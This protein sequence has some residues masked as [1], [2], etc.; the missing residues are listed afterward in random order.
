MG[1]NTGAP[2]KA[3]LVPQSVCG[4]VDSRQQ[5]F[6]LDNLR[7]E[8]TPRSLWGNI[9]ST[10]YGGCKAVR[11]S[12]YRANKVVLVLALFIMGGGSNTAS[13][14]HLDKH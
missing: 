2:R 8:E 11:L 14:M 3:R 12:G 7:H 4:R 9:W 13:S 1:M 5:K 10:E 6:F